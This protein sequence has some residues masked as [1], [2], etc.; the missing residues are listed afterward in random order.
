MEDFTK[1]MKRNDIEEELVMRPINSPDVAN[2]L[3]K[4]HFLVP[5]RFM[6]EMTDTLVE[7]ALRNVAIRKDISLTDA[8]NTKGEQI[9]M[10]HPSRQTP[11]FILHSI[12][13]PTSHELTKQHLLLLNEYVADTIDKSASIPSITIDFECEG[14]RYKGIAYP[15]EEEE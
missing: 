14:Q 13:Y 1:H 8:T 6:P 3:I 2:D 7:E 9:A 11:G 15:I 4:G 5:K 10:P 12:S